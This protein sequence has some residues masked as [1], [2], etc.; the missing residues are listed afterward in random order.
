MHLISDKGFENISLST[1]YKIKM[2]EFNSSFSVAK[3]HCTALGND[4][5]VLLATEIQC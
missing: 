5:A 3:L 2:Q 1:L 4:T